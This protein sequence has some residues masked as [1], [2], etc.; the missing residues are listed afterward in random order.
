M[1]FLSLFFTLLLSLNLY[2]GHGVERGSI[3]I[4]DNKNIRPEIKRFIEKQLERCTN[5]E[6]DETFNLDKLEVNEYRVDQG[7]I[8]VEY[9]LQFTYDAVRNDVLTNTIK[10]KILD[11]DF[12]NWRDYEEKLSLE[13]TYDQNNFCN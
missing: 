6:K 4:D 7:I 1:K 2:A 3:R 11:S 10:V 5:G 9:H 12:D 13:I 8:D